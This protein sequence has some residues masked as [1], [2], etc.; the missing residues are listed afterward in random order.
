MKEPSALTNR[1]STLITFIWAASALATIAGPSLTSGV[2]ITNPWAPWAAR[3]SIAASTFSPSGVPMVSNSK[4]SSSA[5]CW[6]NFHSLRN[7]GSSGCLTR[8]PILTG[9]VTAGVGA[10][11][12]DGASAGGSAR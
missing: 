4:P 1:S 3:L 6:A 5:A 7:Q 8:K 10:G 11:A 9:P 12:D 2:Q